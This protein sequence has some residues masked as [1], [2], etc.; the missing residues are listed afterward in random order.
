MKIIEIKSVLEP[1]IVKELHALNQDNVPALGSLS[2]EAELEELIKL[3]DTSMYILSNNEIIGFLVCFREQSKYHSPNYRFFNN[4]E[5]K[6]MYV[7]RIAIKQNN[8]GKGLGSQ[9]YKRLYKI[10][11]TKHLPICCEVNT[12]PKNQVSLNFHYKNNFK[13]VGEFDFD[14][15]SVVYLKKEDHYLN[16]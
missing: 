6:F 2:T 3:S 7:D 1:K 12:I 16:N 10:A 8:L 9:L 5:S 15:H 11:G 13:S 14:D 4:S